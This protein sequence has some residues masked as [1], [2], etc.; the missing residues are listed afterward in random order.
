MPSG[1]AWCVQV[2]EELY[3][4]CCAV[5]GASLH[6]ADRL[7]RGDADVAINWGGGRCGGVELLPALVSIYVARELSVQPTQ[8]HLLAVRSRAADAGCSVC[9]SCWRRHDAKALKVLLL[10]FD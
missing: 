3:D 8:R 9:V 6:A 2:F 7:C 5:A 10:C 4:Y 1:L